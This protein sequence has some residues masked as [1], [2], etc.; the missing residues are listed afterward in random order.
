MQ[1]IS[2]TTQRA[3]IQIRTERAQ[4]QI[5]RAR[6]RM[7][8]RTRK[9][10]MNVE[11][12]SP[13]F[14]ISRQLRVDSA[15]A[16]ALQRAYENYTSSGRKTAPQGISPSVSSQGSHEHAAHGSDG[17]L[18]DMREYASEQA[19]RSTAKAAARR[20]SAVQ[21]IQ[22]QIEWD[23]GYSDI[24]WEPFEMVI[25]WDM[26]IRPKVS[27]IPHS[28]EIKLSRY[29]SVKVNINAEYY[30]RLDRRKFEKKI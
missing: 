15:T 21:T 18:Q 11:R 28:I 29:P 8:I 17:N 4:V 24:T 23:M 20:P 14:R 16:Q 22:Q 9:A 2:I 6:P 13:Q 10:R 5:E 30:E 1:G 19:Q 25:D 27:V 3:Q 26:D 7:N 12:R